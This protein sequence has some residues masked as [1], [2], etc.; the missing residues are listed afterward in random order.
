MS[1]KPQNMPQV[2]K[3]KDK[4]PAEMQITAEQLLSEAKE[5][6]LEIVPPPPR[7]KIADPKELQE[8]QLKKRR[9]FEDNIRKNRGNVSNWLKYSKWEEEQGEIRRAWSVYERALDV[10]HHNITLWLK[11]A[12]MEMRCKQVNHARNVWDRG[13]TILPQ[14]SQ[15]WYKYTYMEEMLRNPAGARE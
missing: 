13:V 11:Y 5:R 3:V 6:E 2:A 12:E 4:S 15:F 7:Q 14:A 10:E 1:T 9:A 8:Y